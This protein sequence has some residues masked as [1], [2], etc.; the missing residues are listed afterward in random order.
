MPAELEQDEHDERAA[1][2]AQVVAHESEQH[3]YFFFLVEVEGCGGTR[4]RALEQ[5]VDEL[6]RAGGLAVEHRVHAREGEHAQVADEGRRRDAQLV[7]V[8]PDEV[9]EGR[10]ELRR[11]LLASPVRLSLRG[12]GASRGRTTAG[13]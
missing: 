7:G 5:H 6:L 8:G 1:V 10:V 11:R 12:A 13:R 3:C 9:D 2:G 4:E